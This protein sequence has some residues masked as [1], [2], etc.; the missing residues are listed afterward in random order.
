MGSDVDSSISVESFT[1]ADT[2]SIG[3]V[4]LHAKLHPKLV[5]DV[6]SVNL[7]AL[8]VL[9]KRGNAFDVMT[10]L[11]E[12]D[13]L[14]LF[15]ESDHVLLQ[16]AIT[17][18][19]VAIRLFVVL[20]NHSFNALNSIAIRNQTIRCVCRLPLPRAFLPPQTLLLLVLL[21][22]RVLPPPR[23]LPPPRA[24]FFCDF[25]TQADTSPVLERLWLEKMTRTAEED[26]KPLLPAMA[27]LI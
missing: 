11:H 19:K 20:T 12:R 3:N 6:P 14:L 23:L 21:P 15:I 25:K 9:E 1:I 8:R 7:V 10:F 16:S 4:D 18:G 27:T 13:L 2:A 26:G 24:L 5:T 22:L 17:L